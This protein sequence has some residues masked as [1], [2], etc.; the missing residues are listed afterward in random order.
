MSEDKEKS[1]HAGVD[2]QKNQAL[3]A[4][5]GYLKQQQ[6][7]QQIGELN[8]LQN[9]PEENRTRD[10]QNNI[11]ALLKLLGEGATPQRGSGWGEAVRGSEKNGQNQTGDKGR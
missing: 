5:I 8:R 2:G 4:T 9:I 1:P 11:K 6:R 3:P 10:D 7:I